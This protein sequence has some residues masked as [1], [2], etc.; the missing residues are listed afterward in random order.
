MQGSVSIS[1][2]GDVKIHTYTAPENGLLVNTH[3]IELPRQL[4]AVDAQ[5]GLPYAAEVVEYAKSLHS[6]SAASMSLTSTPTTSSGPRR[7]RRRS[8]RWRR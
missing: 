1:D 8:T 4:L 6:R 2:R 5:Y 7:S 3:L